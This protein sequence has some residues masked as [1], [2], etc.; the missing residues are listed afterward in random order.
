MFGLMLWEKCLESKLKS[1]SPSVFRS[2][3]SEIQLEKEVTVKQREPLTS[4]DCSTQKKKR[5]VELMMCSWKRDIHG[6]WTWHSGRRH[7]FFW[8]NVGNTN[9]DRCDSLCMTS[10]SGGGALFHATFSSDGSLK[11]A[12]D[13]YKSTSGPL[14]YLFVRCVH[15]TTIIITYSRGCFLGGR[16]AARVRM[17]GL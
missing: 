15:L 8:M 11:N 14:S 12:V 16:L 7:L 4:V 5:T 1:F 10:G 17:W 6:R 3:R 2:A 9:S 13:A